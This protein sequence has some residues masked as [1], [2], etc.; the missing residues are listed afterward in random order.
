L[1]KAQL[2]AA[3]GLEDAVGERTGQPRRYHHQ[4]EVPMPVQPSDFGEVLLVN[5]ERLF[6]D[7]LLETEPGQLFQYLDARGRRAAQV[8]D[9]AA[10]IDHV[11]GLRQ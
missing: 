7:D 1:E 6:Y 9:R 3:Q 2:A 10:G 8:H 4:V 5:R 11:G